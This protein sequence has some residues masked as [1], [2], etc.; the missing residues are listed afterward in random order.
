VS[1][2]IEKNN[3]VLSYAII[4]LSTAKNTTITKLIYIFT[5]CLKKVCYFLIDT[6]GNMPIVFLCVLGALGG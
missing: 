3:V 6:Q 2:N 1:S 5:S 4:N